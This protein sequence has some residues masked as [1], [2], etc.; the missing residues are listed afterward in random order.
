M[1]A[2]GAAVTVAPDARG[3]IALRAFVPRRY[4]TRTY[5]AAVAKDGTIT[6]T[7]AKVVPALQESEGA[8]HG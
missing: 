6:L 1:R 7:P 4:R 5:L 3:R 2:I 8:S